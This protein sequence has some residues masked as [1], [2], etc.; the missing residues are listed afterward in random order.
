MYLTIYSFESMMSR[1][2]SIERD[3][4]SIYFIFFSDDELRLDTC[5][6]E[7]AAVGHHGFLG[8]SMARVAM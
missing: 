1:K 5:G 3:S 7:I 8:G 6:A 2:V 4:A